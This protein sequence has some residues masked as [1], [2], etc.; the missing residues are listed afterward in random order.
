MKLLNWLLSRSTRSESLSVAVSLLIL[1]IGAGLMMST[2][3]GWGKLTSFSERAAQFS[4]P[5]GLGSSLSMGL[6][7]FAEFF[8]SMALI[9]G[10]FT[11]AA[12]IPLMF[13]MLVAVLIVHADDPFGRKELALLYLL[14][15]ITVL[16]C[17]PGRFSLDRL[18]FG[19]K[20]N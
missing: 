6:A 11:R 7:I 5:I 3:H 9:L 19:K 20:E 12:V 14:P 2:A 16:L 8:C 10:L 15:Y 13:T 18:L 4:D 1:R 17:G